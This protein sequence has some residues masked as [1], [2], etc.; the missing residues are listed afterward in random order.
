[1]GTKTSKRT[2]SYTFT[3][4]HSLPCSAHTRAEHGLGHQPLFGGETWRQSR[5]APHAQLHF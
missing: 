2:L 4:A 3:L 5:A 1:M